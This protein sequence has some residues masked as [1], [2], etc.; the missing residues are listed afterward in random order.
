LAANHPLRLQEVDMPKVL[1]TPT[2]L[3]C[4]GPHT[5]LLREAG[6]EIVF[7]KRQAQLTEQ[8]LLDELPGIA[9]ALAGSEPYTALVLEQAKALRVIARAGV[10]YDAVDLPAASKHGVAVAITPGANH[11]AVAEHTL[12]MLLA[13][14]KNLRLL[15]LTTRQG[16]WVRTPTLPLRGQT[17]GIVGLGRIGK[18][19]AVRARALGMKLLVTEAAPDRAFIAAHGLGLVPLERLLAESDYVTLHAPL[20]P[21]T[22]RLIRRETLAQMKPTA[23]LINT[24]RGGLICERDLLEALRAKRIGGAALDVFEQEPPGPSPF[25]ELDN[26]LLT[27]HIAGIDE[28]SRI[29]LGVHAAR[30]IVALSRGEWPADQIVNQDLRAR[31]RW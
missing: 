10:G 1:V 14:A 9:A 20:L 7:P 31:F 4:E 21:A 22:Q 12:A 24:A 19:V 27:P 17:L 8:E 2:T 11:D 3:T 29:E 5:A 30:A 26:V 6:F 13:V 25:F 15:D 28:V 16:K 18:S 23:W